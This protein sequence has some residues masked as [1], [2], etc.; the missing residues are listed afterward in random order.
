ML[1]KQF[2]EHIMNKNDYIKTSVYNLVGLKDM[3]MKFFLF[4]IF[5]LILNK[6]SSQSNTRTKV[7]MKSEKQLIDKL[8][9]KYDK[10]M[11]PSDTVEIKF[12]LYLNQ[13][14]TLIEQEQI[15]V[16]NVFLDHEWLDERLKWD[17]TQ[18]NNVTLLRISSDLLWT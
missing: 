17:S 14:V 9:Q 13:I 2:S 1:F 8:L 7:L 10:N 12:S 18:H 5:F 3:K 4:L 16:I 11:R 6:I 15:F